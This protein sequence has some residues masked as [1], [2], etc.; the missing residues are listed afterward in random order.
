MKQII[1]IFVFVCINWVQISISAKSELDYHRYLQ[2]F[3]Y[4]PK[5]EGR[6]LHSIV[7]KAAYNEGIKKFQR[8]YKLPVGFG[9]ELISTLTFICT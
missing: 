8:L 7:S 6:L 1:Y 2:Q 5:A 4:A 9:I 3:G